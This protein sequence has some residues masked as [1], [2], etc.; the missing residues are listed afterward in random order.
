MLE[1]L[2][3]RKLFGRHA[4]ARNETP[5]EGA[6]IEVVL[7]RPLQDGLRTTRSANPFEQ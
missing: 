4:H 7:A 6:G 2:D 1:T 5:F 3:A